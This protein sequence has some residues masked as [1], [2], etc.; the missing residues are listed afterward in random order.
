M[1]HATYS[2]MKS[3]SVHQTV[4]LESQLWKYGWCKEGKQLYFE[5]RKR[6]IGNTDDK[7]EK[8]T[9]LKN[10]HA[11]PSEGKLQVFRD[12]CPLDRSSKTYSI[13]NL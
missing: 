4:T 11:N 8:T 12:R 2:E 10:K 5:I 3:R 9:L 13:Y 6:L 7:E 1:N